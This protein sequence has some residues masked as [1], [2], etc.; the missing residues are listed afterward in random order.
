VSEILAGVGSLLAFAILYVC[1]NA[2]AEERRRRWLE[3]H[4][5]HD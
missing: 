2:R 1:I 4:R 5:H 3:R